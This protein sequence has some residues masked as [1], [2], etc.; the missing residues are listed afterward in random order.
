[1]SVF[2]ARG[3]L[4]QFFQ[5]RVS[6]ALENQRISRSAEAEFYLVNLLAEFSA[7]ENFTRGA[8]GRAVHAPLALKLKDALE[9]PSPQERLAHLRD[10]GDLALYVAGFF[11]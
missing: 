3:E 1:M 10:L 11:S 6:S 8:E 7:A 2:S 9:A 5:E 4:R